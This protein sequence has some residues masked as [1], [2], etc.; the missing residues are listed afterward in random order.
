M[1]M[2]ILFRQQNMNFRIIVDKELERKLS[3]TN[4]MDTDSSINQFEDV[5]FNNPEEKSV[6]FNYKGGPDN[7]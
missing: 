3:N 5:S 6:S 7:K 4:I 2:D 1:G